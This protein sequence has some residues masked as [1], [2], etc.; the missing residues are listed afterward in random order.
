MELLNPL[1]PRWRRWLLRGLVVLATLLAAGFLLPHPARV[2]RTITLRAPPEAV[3]ERL[4]TLRHWPEW[5][6]WT[7]NR[8]PDLIYRFDG[9]A[10][11]RGRR[12]E[13]LRLDEGASRAGDCQVG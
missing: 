7:T 3:F 2:I 8:F 12:E 9:P 6:A 4:A 1:P 11:E 13:A 10:Q 5:T